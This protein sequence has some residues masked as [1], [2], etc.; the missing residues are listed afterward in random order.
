MELES[1]DQKRRAEEI[2]KREQEKA[3][4]QRLLEI[5]RKKEALLKEEE[6]RKKQEEF[7]SQTEKILSEQQKEVDKRKQEID[8]RDQERRDFMLKKQYERAKMA[9]QKRALTEKKIE[10][11]RQAAEMAIQ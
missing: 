2:F 11:T 5:Q 9:S 4:K 3:E 6:R 7:Q 8:K 10:Q 1:M